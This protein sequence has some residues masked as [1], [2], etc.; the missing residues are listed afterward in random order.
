LELTETALLVAV[1]VGG[2]VE[3]LPGALT[4]VAGYD[5]DRLVAGEPGLADESRIGSD[6]L[7]E[8]FE[9]TDPRGATLAQRLAVLVE[10]AA[11]RLIALTGRQAGGVVAVLPDEAGGAAAAVL[12]Q[13]IEAGGLEVLRLIRPSD[14]DPGEPPVLAAARIA[15]DMR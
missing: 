2:N 3:R 11:K 8:A 12:F 1:S 5:G 13:A 7:V 9:E 14:A 10:A 15:E 6:R 4:A